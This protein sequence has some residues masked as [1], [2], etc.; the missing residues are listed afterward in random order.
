MGEALVLDTCA[1][2]W[3]VQGGGRLT[4]ATIARIDEANEVV[5]SGISAFEIGLKAERGLLELPLPVEKWFAEVC[6]THRLREIPL[7]GSL[8]ARACRLPAIHKDPCDRFIIATAFAQR[9]PVVTADAIYGRYGV[10]IM[11]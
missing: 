2:L 10:E 9:C 6:S 5:V 3:L 8:A 1:L 7:N 4:A 11:S